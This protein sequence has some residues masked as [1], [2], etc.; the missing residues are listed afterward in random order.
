MA[1]VPPAADQLKTLGFI[2]NIES[3]EPA[4]GGFSG[5][6]ATMPNFALKHGPEIIVLTKIW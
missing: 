5:F 1:K 4:P 2:L 6:V 3:F